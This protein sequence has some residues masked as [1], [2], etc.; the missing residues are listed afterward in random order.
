MTLKDRVEVA[1]SATLGKVE[2][3]FFLIIIVASTLLTASL[4]APCRKRGITM[5][6]PAPPYEQ[7]P[8]Y[9]NRSD[10]IVMGTVESRADTVKGALDYYYELTLNVERTIKGP[11]TDSMVV[12]VEQEEEPRGWLYRP[13]ISVGER[14][15][16]FLFA[17]P[18]DTADTA[19][20]P[21]VSEV[22]SGASYRT[23]P[24]ES[25]I[26]RVECSEVYNRWAKAMREYHSKPVSG[27]RMPG[28]RMPDAMREEWAEQFH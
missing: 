4:L 18:A 15:I 20:T 25:L 26:W 12:R 9:A 17:I 21:E 6:W 5:I 14:V 2:I 10:A 28:E 11:Q 22:S 16:L 23:G 13:Q 8:Y 1:R 24:I 19:D 3:G 7:V 27:E